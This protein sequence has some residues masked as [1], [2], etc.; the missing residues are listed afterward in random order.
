MLSDID[1]TQ[2]LKGLLIKKVANLKFLNR[3]SYHNTKP[4]TTMG[5]KLTLRNLR[6]HL[7]YLFINSVLINNL[8]HDFLVKWQ[9]Y[10]AF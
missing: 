4:Q 6:K 10:K 3:G 1:L 5:F 8:N 9:I 2:R 7:R